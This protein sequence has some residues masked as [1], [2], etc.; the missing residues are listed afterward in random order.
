ANGTAGTSSATIQLT[1]AD[2]DGTAS[3]D[4]TGWTST[5]NANLFTKSGTYGTATLDVSTGVVTYVL[6]NSKTATQ[7]LTA[8]ASA[9][10]SFAVSVT[11]NSG[12]TASTTASFAITGSNDA[13]TITSGT[14]GTVTENAPT[15]TVIYTAQA[16]DPDLGDAIT[17]SLSGADADKLNINSATGAVTLKASADFETKASY[18]FNVIATDRAGATDLK[19]VTVSVANLPNPVVNGGT[20]ATVFEAGLRSVANTTETATGTFT[21]NAA[22]QAYALTLGGTSISAVGNQVA[23]GKG[24]LTITSISAPDANG[25][26]TYGYSYTLTAAQTHPAGSTTVNDTI[27]ISVTS[28]NGEANLTPGSIVIAITDD[29]PDALTPASI[30]V[31]NAAGAP[32]S[33]SL[34][35][36]GIVTNNYGADSAGATV[37]FDPALNGTDSTLTSGFTKII[38]TLVDNYTLVGMAGAT[39]IFTI[40]LDPAK[41]TYSVDMDGKID[42]PAVIDYNAGGYTF[43]GGNNSWAG[44]FGTPT[45]TIS[46]DLLLTPGVVDAN[47]IVT[48]ASTINT[49]ATSGGVGS[50]ASVGTGEVFRVDFVNNL[51]GDPKDGSGQYENLANRDHTFDSH[52]TVNGASALFEATNGSTIKITAKDDPDGNNVVGDG[53]IDKITAVGISYNNA[54]VTVTP[55]SGGTTVVV[56]G[57]TF[58]VTLNADNSVNVAG[59]TSTTGGASIGTIISV[60]TA[61]GY[62][63]VE[64]AHVS[65]ST[66]QIGDFGVTTLTTNPVTWT[67]PVQV[68]DGDGDIAASNL[69][70]TANT[71]VAPIVLD[72][73]GD[74]VQ[75]LGLADGVQY[76]FGGAIG[77]VH[78]AWVGAG[79]GFLAEMRA[80]GTINIVFSTTAGQ[81]DLQ[82]L[83]QTHDTNADGV[84]S[85]ADQGFLSFGV[86]RDVNGD[87]VFEAGEFMTLT[88]AGIASINLTS[89]GQQQIAANGDVLIHGS[90]TFTMLDG[91]TG[92]VQDVAF[93]TA[94]ATPP[95]ATPAETS[96]DTGAGTQGFAGHRVDLEAE[97]TVD[98]S[99]VGAALPPPIDEI[100]IAWGVHEVQDHGG[101]SDGAFAV[102]RSDAPMVV[103]ESG[104]WTICVDQ[105]DHGFNPIA[106]TIEQQEMHQIL[107]GEPSTVRID[108]IS[109]TGAHEEYLLQGVDKISWG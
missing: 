34:D 82:G 42:S 39:K 15:S 7:A 98:F 12:A 85:I 24:T 91:S 69:S 56:G 72:L 20:G 97:P 46:K 77:T 57:K 35:T 6:D 48:N 33:A 99:A 90:T 1:K 96:D 107:F 18:S 100:D 101:W 68:I 14:T 27:A 59:V 32:V 2:V 43:Q 28:S 66:F 58:T 108:F 23:T 93:V 9:T 73:N 54:S 17:Y 103:P 40:T 38:Y 89:D 16:T 102:A 55:V 80:D 104:G 25:L 74:G 63:S 70:I 79:D 109:P 78:T 29:S 44:F 22:N 76:D 88:D 52:Y 50:G 11:D 13:P 87:G 49:S 31:G 47:G 92:I 21:V 62:N 45:G 10:D 81:T 8:G 71:V 3:Y 94:A 84:F 95:P 30:S 37:R 65:G 5:A 106:P 53:R 36:D 60:F 4:T 41:G 64:Y 105:G 83:A 86:W 61:D 75:Y 51:K 67:V 26:V 19:A